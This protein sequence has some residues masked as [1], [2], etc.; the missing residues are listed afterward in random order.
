MAEETPPPRGIKRSLSTPDKAEEARPKPFSIV[1]TGGPCGG[2]SSILAV[3]RDRLRKRGMQVIA[4]PEYATHFFAN[5]D[6]FQL[7]WVGTQK[8]QGLQNVLLK[9]QMMQEDLFRDFAGLNTKTSV[10]L[11]DRGTL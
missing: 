2:K 3:I 6:G 11:L 4:V 10:L 7:D 9:Y 5:S 8:E 1:L